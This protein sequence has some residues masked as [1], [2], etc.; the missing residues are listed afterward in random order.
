MLALDPQGRQMEHPSESR[1]LCA[2]AALPVI[3]SAFLA[4]F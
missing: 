2:E 3:S 4:A 1:G